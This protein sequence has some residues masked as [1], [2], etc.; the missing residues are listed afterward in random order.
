[1][2]EDDTAILPVHPLDAALKIDAYLQQTANAGAAE[3]IL[4][5]GGIVDQLDEHSAALR[6]AVHVVQ[7][8]LAPQVRVELPFPCAWFAPWSRSDGVAALRETLAL[9]LLTQEPSLIEQCLAEPTIRNVYT[10]GVPTNFGTKTMPHDGYLS[11]F[12]MEVKGYAQR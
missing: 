7:T 3:A 2:P 1:M 12:L 8:P 9:S 6:P 4:G 11:A 5:G 10:G